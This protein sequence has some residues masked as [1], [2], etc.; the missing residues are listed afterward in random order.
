MSS[1]TTIS[2]TTNIVSSSVSTIAMSVRLISSLLRSSGGTRRSLDHSGCR[3][4]DWKIRRHLVDDLREGL[5]GLRLPLLHQLV[6]KFRNVAQA[7]LLV[8]RRVLRIE[9]V[10]APGAVPLD[11]AEAL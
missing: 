11:H 8:D 9:G 1:S 2:V 4:H 7:V 6:K 5:L 10:L 3:G